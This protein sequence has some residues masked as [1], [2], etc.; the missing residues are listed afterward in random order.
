MID[1]PDRV[2]TKYANLVVFAVSALLTEFMASVKVAIAVFTRFILLRLSSATN[3]L[4]PN[5]PAIVLNLSPVLASMLKDVKKFSLK[6]LAPSVFLNASASVLIPSPTFSIR[7]RADPGYSP[8]RLDAF[9]SSSP[10]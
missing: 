6:L 2:S 10:L 9:S 7:A 3:G 8:R 4:S 1:K 5:N